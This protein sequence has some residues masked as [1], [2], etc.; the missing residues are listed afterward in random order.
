MSLPNKLT[1][2]LMLFFFPPFLPHPFPTFSCRLLRVSIESGLVPP[3][4]L[5]CL[6]Q[7]Y[8]QHLQKSRVTKKI[9][10]FLNLISS[11][12][13]T[14]TTNPPPHPPSPP[15]PPLAPTKTQNNPCVS[16]VRSY[17]ST[18]PSRRLL[19]QER[20]RQRRHSSGSPLESNVTDLTCA[21]NP[22]NGGATSSSRSYDDLLGQIQQTTTTTT[23]K[24]VKFILP[25]GSAIL[26][27]PNS[28]SPSSSQVVPHHHHHHQLVATPYQ[29]H[30]IPANSGNPTSTGNPAQVMAICCP[31]YYIYPNSSYLSALYS[32]R[33]QQNSNPSNNN[34]S[35][36]LTK[37][38]DEE[39]DDDRPGSETECSFI[40]RSRLI[41][42]NN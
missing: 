18:L 41:N 29:L 26:S 14:S 11:H 21:K 35:N 15:S 33:Q 36:M 42:N 7:P 32:Y 17:S 37:V 3:W 13:S 20:D 23:S 38:E 8:Q 10:K 34:S 31:Y 2:F 6:P 9:P 24:T 19:K 27:K 25:R 5:S 16:V 39:E 1:K 22:A 12:K 40:A 30:L 4:C 28:S